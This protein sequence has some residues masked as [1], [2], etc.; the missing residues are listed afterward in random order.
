MADFTWSFSALKTY[1]N[2]P[3]RY[4][5]EIVAKNFK[6]K[7]SQAMIYGNAVHHALEKYVKEGTPLP[8]YYERFKKDVDTLLEIPG[9]K[10]TEHRM[11]LTRDL[12]PCEY[13]DNT[14]WVRGIADLVIVDGD[15]AFIIDYKT[16][17]DKYPDL[18]QLRLMSHMTFA[19]F[20]QVKKIK[21]ALLFLMNSNFMPEE[22]VRDEIPKSWDN[23]KVPLTRL[24][25]SLDTNTWIPNPTPLCGYCPVTTCEFNKT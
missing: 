19:H 17:S 3:R 11:G 18:K 23:F 6:Q 2:C 20:P 24:E 21:A 22:Y 10:L 8:K 5:E 16:G 14:R 4:Y 15:Y 13:G 25:N 1:Q 12:S 9:E 7:P